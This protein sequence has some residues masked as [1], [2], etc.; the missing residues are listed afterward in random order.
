VTTPAPTT[1]VQ[2]SQCGA[3]LADI[4]TAITADAVPSALAY[5]FE[6]TNGATVRTIETTSGSNRS[7]LLTSLS[8]GAMY[9]T[10]YSVR[11]A[12][13]Y[14]SGIWSNYGSSC[15]VTTPPP[16]SRLV[17]N[18]CN[19]TLSDMSIPL[20]VLPIQGVTQYRVEVSGG[21]LASP[22][23]FFPAAG[24]TSVQL[25]TTNVFNFNTTY[26]VRVNSYYN[27]AWR[28]YGSACNITTPVAQSLTIRPTECG[29][30][31]AALNNLIYSVSPSV[32]VTK[33]R[34]ELT[35]GADVI[36][37]E[38]SI[39]YFKFAD[40]PGNHMGKTYAVRV[41]YQYNGVWSAYGQSC[42]VTLAS[43]L[44]KVRASQCGTTVSNTTWVY[45]DNLFVRPSR[46]R[47]ELTAGT[48]VL[49][50]ETTTNSFRFRDVS[51]YQNGTA[52]SVRVAT[53]YNNVWYPYGQS[54][55][56]TT[57][58]TAPTTREIVE[59]VPSK[60]TIFAVKGYPNPYNAYFTLS[61]DTP[62][63]AMVYV[64]VFDMTGK[65]IED[66]EVA[67]SALESLQLGADWA[68]G[69]YNVIVAQ[70]DQVKTIR[71][72]KKE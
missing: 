61:L 21:G 8:G 53:Q 35:S 24:V 9:A 59:E 67:P 64:R 47:F 23:V 66:R 39:R 72:V 32:Q 48:T 41:A 65:L 40:V 44:T 19:S 16:F 56:I 38:T 6:V 11:V 1:K 34:F 5:R 20:N 13:K 37:H 15:N 52:Y 60:A 3:T 4:G 71:M 46:Y 26:S 33:Y 42:N 45:T 51:G 31:N 14:G 18:Q 27:G 2:A 43:P 63:D 62:S 58:G 22:Y 12:V 25:N 70:D 17:S 57:S 29:L 54:C 28:G 68:S 7:M 10:T 30:T 50:Y 36:T 69:V 49:T 55:V